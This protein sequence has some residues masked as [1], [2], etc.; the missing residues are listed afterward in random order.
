MGARHRRRRSDQSAYD[1]EAREMR[2]AHHRA[3]RHST[4]QALHEAH[5]EDSLDDVVLPEPKP[6]RERVAPEERG[7]AKVGTHA[8]RP[9]KQPF[10]KR[11]RNVRRERAIAWREAATG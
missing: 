10:W 3:Q 5:F 6:T 1:T 8:F 4:R 11:R 7:P 2:K 9:W